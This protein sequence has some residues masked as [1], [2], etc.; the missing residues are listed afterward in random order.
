MICTPASRN[1]SGETL[2]TLACVPTG[3]KIGVWMVPW[4]VEMVP[5]RAQLSE[6]SASMVNVNDDMDSMVV[7]SEKLL[8]MHRE[9]W[10]DTSGQRGFALED[11]ERTI[12]ALFKR[13]DFHGA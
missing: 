8:D 10:H 6:H 9:I 7:L 4:G 3:M 1:S 13:E 12:G 5:A 2:F 11:P